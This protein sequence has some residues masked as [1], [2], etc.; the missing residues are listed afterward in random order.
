M[1]SS[2]EISPDILQNA[3]NEIEDYAIII[4]DKS[5]NIIEWNKGAEKIK[6]YTASEITGKNFKKFYTLADINSC[7]PDSLLEE[8]RING[9]AT[10]EGWRV[11]K[12]GSKFWASVVITAIHDKEDNVI[13]YS[14]VTKDHTSKKLYQDKL[15][16]LDLAISE[17]ED[18][19]IILLDLNGNIQNW[20]KGAKKIKGYET[21]EI[22]GSS[23][24]NFYSKEDQK[25]QKPQSLLKQAL[26]YGKANDE[27]WRIRKDG[28][29]F[30]ASVTI[31]TIV[32]PEG[33]ISG[34]SKV[35]RDL[36][37]R[38]KS[39][40]ERKIYI[41]QIEA[42]NQELE[43]FA[44]IASHDLQEPLRTM[45]SLTSLFVDGYSENIDEE[46]I[47]MLNYL[48]QASKRM[49]NL[50]HGLLEYSRIGR[51][52]DFKEVNI[53][54]ILKTIQLDLSVTIQESEA[55][56]HCENLPTIMGGEIELSQ[57]FQNLISNAIK[58]Q[59]KGNK[60]IIEINATEKA[61][62]W[63]FEVKD[64]G[65]GIP[66]EDQKDI[67]LIF[68]RLHSR[69]KFQ[70]TGIGLAHCK[71]I[72]ELHHGNIWVESTQDMGSS[73]YFCVSKNPN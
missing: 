26:E 57:L 48:Q 19:A 50:I 28:S 20:N 45:S 49:S 4:L 23:F 71:K 35:T 1:D 3:I 38:K 59:P 12:D 8:A 21:Q 67:F 13:G 6:G 27:G 69:E 16:Q 64:N 53:N 46:G 56:I 60:P 41:N 11:R 17:I 55:E 40:E 73:F 18:Y 31:S 66:E 24:T 42:K 37:E 62:Q 36:T 52:I 22:I 58:F 51:T 47:Q 9:T 2:F 61:N 14:K 72:V 32:N 70:G 5:G 10:N 25:N 30:W 65:I 43:Q 39:E 63:V 34:F 15:S 33:N 7:K 44:Y 29:K 54:N 68:K